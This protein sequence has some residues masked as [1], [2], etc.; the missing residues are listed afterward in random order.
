MTA[1]AILQLVSVLLGTGGIVA[2]FLITEKKAAAQLANADK[3]NEQWKQIVEQ[4]EKDFTSLN[5]KYEA[6]CKKIDH[7]YDDNSN[8]RTHLD[9]L[10]TECAVSKLMRCNSIKCTDRKPPFGA[11]SSR[12]RAEK[13]PIEQ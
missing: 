4:K 9:D 11:G 1:D 5:E 12:E 8:L 7:L 10:N 13:Q 2:L 6:A 3:I